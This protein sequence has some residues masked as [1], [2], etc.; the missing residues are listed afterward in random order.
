MNSISP[1]YEM[2]VLVIYKEDSENYKEVVQDY[3]QS[4]HVNVHV[5]AISNTQFNSEDLKKYDL[6]YP[7]VSLVD[8][9]NREEIANKLTDYVRDGGN[10]F[11]EEDLYRIFPNDVLGMSKIEEV[12]L[13]NQTFD[14][15]VV[16]QKYEN[17]QK[18]W[19]IYSVKKKENTF[20]NI[21]RSL[22][23]KLKGD[24]N[25]WVKSPDVYDIDLTK[26]NL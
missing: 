15:P 19:K 7:D 6:F 1:N 9:D 8:A 16:P 25:S 13:T 14:F 11:L 18:L 20:Y 22:Y 3:A 23:H 4:L 17:L 10:L 21:I 12:N 5:K 26:I 24:Y 2:N